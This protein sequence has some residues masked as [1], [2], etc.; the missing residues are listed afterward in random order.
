VDHPQARLHVN[1]DQPA[2]VKMGKD[3]VEKHPDV[4]VKN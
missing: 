2:F 3:F 4:G 1:A